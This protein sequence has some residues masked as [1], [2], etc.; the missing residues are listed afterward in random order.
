MKNLLLTFSR[1]CNYG[2][3]LQTYAS[4]KFFENSGIELITPAYSPIYLMPTTSFYRGIGLR[5]NKKKKFN[6]LY[7]IYRRLKMYKRYKLFKDFQNEYLKIDYSLDSVNSII[8]SSNQYHS[9]VVGADQ[10][11]NTN[12]N[13]SSNFENYFFLGFL[14]DSTIKKISFSSCFGVDEKN[15][16]FSNEIKNCV[17]DFDYLSTRNEFSKK[18][19][20][21]YTDKEI[22]T[23]C[24]PTIIHDFNELT[25]NPREEN[26]ILIYSM[27]S[28]NLSLIKNISLNLKKKYN[29]KIYSISSETRINMN[30]VDKN[31][32][33][34][35]PI[36][37]LNLFKKS[38]FIL[39][40]SFHGS[41]FS[42]KFKKKFLSFSTNYRSYRIKSLL[43]LFDL[44]SLH[45]NNDNIN[46]FNENIWKQINIEKIEST[47][48]DLK[49]KAADFIK[50]S[51]SL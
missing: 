26:I 4:I 30:W 34:A 25:S 29:S 15:Q 44:E 17:V 5:G 6:F 32:D 16:K 36:E 41:I 37:F 38:R 13:L 50:T 19:L 2:A 22:F 18:I 10:T 7:P 43:K 39:T 8:N 9:F 28:S 27:D 20:E 35:G 14:K 11:W 40:D 48:D 12:L 49:R 33:N 3:A 45:F 31:I 23:L 24:D 51:Y 1:T 21:Q 47:T 42:I 46:E